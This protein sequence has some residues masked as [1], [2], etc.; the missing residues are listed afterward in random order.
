[1]LGRLLVEVLQVDVVEE[2]V[3]KF[4]EQANWCSR[5][6]ISSSRVC[7]LIFGPACD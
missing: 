3:A 2:M 7:D 1:M 4:W 6:K 5:L